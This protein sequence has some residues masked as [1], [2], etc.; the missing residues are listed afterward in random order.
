M[1]LADLEKVE[2]ASRTLIAGQSQSYWLL[3]AL[4]SQLKRDGFKPSDPLLF[5]KNISALSAS[6]TSIS[7]NEKRIL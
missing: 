7:T 6:Q 1:I 3:S 2:K 5:D 4:L